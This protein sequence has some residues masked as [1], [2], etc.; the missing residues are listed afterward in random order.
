MVQEQ[1]LLKVVS[2]YFS[3]FCLNLPD[4]KKENKMHLIHAF[5]RQN[6][7]LFVILGKGFE[8]YIS[9]DAFKPVFSV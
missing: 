1:I 7:I 9:V 2:L 4:F 8:Y 3:A 6:E 5:F